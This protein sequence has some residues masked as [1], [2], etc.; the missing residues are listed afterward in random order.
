MEILRFEQV[1]ESVPQRKK[2]SRGFLAIGLVA[3][4]FG[5]STAFASSTIT[6]NS[7]LPIQLGQGV[8]TVVACDNQIGVT[9][10]TSLADDASTFFLNTVKVGTSGANLISATCAGKIFRLTFYDDA[11]PPAKVSACSD[12]ALISGYNL[13]YVGGSG[14]FM[15]HKCYD[16]SVYIRVDKTLATAGTFT[17]TW[18]SNILSTP[19]LGWDLKTREFGRI[20]VETVD[21]ESLP[22]KDSGDADVANFLS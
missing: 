22:F 3:A 15:A 6:V 9:P 2:S 18:G 14:D 7:D 5:I 17:V 8:T 1:P 12:A 21:Q 16:K 10:A 19:K 11:N 4:L 20:V 13:S